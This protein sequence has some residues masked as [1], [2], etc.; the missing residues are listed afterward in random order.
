[1]ERYLSTFRITVKMNMLFIFGSKFIWVP[2]YLNCLLG[3]YSNVAC[4]TRGVLHA[5]G[6]GFV[7]CLPPNSCLHTCKT[8][9]LVSCLKSKHSLMT[10]VV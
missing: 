5:E 3:I 1:M 9:K 8:V 7:K 4:L 2:K 10:S 6:H